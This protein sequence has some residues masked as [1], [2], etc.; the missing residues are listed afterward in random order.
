MS[1]LQGFQSEFRCAELN[2]RVKLQC[3]WKKVGVQKK[4][5]VLKLMFD[6]LLQKLWSTIF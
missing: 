1:H 2:K 6:N 3:I 5:I 4:N